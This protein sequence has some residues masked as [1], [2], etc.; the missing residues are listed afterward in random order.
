MIPTDE[1]IFLRGGGQPPTRYV[2]IFSATCVRV[3]GS[4]P[5]GRELKLPAG[6]HC[7]H[8]P[9]YMPNVR[10]DARKK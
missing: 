1:V 9:D 8:A 5:H 10:I 2:K 3:S 6:R 7:G 4:S